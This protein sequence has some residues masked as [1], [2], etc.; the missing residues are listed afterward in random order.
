MRPG[1]MIGEGSEMVVFSEPFFADVM[2][3][4]LEGDK[5]PVYFAGYIME[6]SYEQTG[7]HQVSLRHLENGV[8]TWLQ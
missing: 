6:R 3:R 8:V 1:L 4:W 7:A 5:V 2:G